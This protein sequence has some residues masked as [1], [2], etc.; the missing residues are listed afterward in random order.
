MAL[1][2]STG[3]LRQRPVLSLSRGAVLSQTV[4]GISTQGRLVVITAL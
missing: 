3:T 4:G 1:S 2:R